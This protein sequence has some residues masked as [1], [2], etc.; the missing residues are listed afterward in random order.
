MSESYINSYENSYIDPYS[1]IENTNTDTGIYIDTYASNESIYWNRESA[2]SALI[3]IF[4]IFIL[5]FLII[6]IFVLF[7]DTV[8]PTYMRFNYSRAEPP[9]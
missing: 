6:I 5:L 4:I 1:S 2:I 9:P 8:L 7:S 3:L